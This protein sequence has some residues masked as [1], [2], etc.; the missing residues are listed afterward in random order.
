MSHTPG[1]SL[2]FSPAALPCVPPCPSVVKILISIADRT[3]LAL[4]SPPRISPPPPRIR[5]SS[6]AN[7]PTPKAKVSTAII[8]SNNG[9]N[10]AREAVFNPFRQWGYLEGDL[11]PLNFLRPRPTPELL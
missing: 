6:K 3:T 4:L 2:F 7:M 11:D 8:E 10:S 5:Y 1:H 9:S